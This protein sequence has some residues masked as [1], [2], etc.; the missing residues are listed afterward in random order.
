LLRLTHNLGRVIPAQKGTLMGIGLPNEEMECPTKR[1]RS[2]RK[3]TSV[4]DVEAPLSRMGVTCQA[5]HQGAGTAKG[6][7]R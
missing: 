2:G 3:T 5:E 1:T 7:L 4:L 6:K